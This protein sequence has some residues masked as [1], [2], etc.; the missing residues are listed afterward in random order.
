MGKPVLEIEYCVQCSFLLR[1]GWMAQELLS[2]FA[3][4]VE[5]VF[6]RP[7]SGGHFLV[8]VDGEE[9]F[10]RKAEGRFPDAKELKQR[11]AARIAPE[12]RFGHEGE[13]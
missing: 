12:R 4:E 1:A 3:G 5:G 8:R 9:I 2:A 11:V 10:S 6:L 13:G 7:G